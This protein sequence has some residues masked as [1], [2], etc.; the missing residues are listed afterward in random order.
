[1][2]NLE[3]LIAESRKKSVAVYLACDAPV[4]TDISNQLNK[5]CE[6]IQDC[7]NEIHDYS[8]RY[9]DG[10]QFIPEDAKVF[11]KQLDEDCKC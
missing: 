9:G 10:S 2:K 5:L 7:V 4:A 11:L 3:I 6:L 8:N 1:M